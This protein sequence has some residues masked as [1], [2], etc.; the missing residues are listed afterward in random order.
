VQPYHRLKET[1]VRGALTAAELALT[2]RAPL[3]FVSSIGALPPY[4]ATAAASGV[5]TVDRG[6]GWK[7]LSHEELEAKSGYG[8]TKGVAEALLLEAAAATPGLDVRV[9]R[10]SAVSGHRT[11][12]YANARDATCLLQAAITTVGAAPA[13]SGLPLRWIPVDFVAAATIRLALAPAAL[14]AGRAFNLITA[15]PPL[16]VAVAAVRAVG[17][18][19]RD[20]P[21]SEWPSELAGLPPGHPALPLA[22]AF[23][24]MDV[25]Q[26]Q[27]GGANSATLEA[28]LPTAAARSALRSLGLP[29]PAPVSS[30]EAT[31]AVMWLARTGGLLPPLPLAQLGAA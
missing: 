22:S 1:N 16:S 24:R 9:V 28:A 23:A 18:P 14:A 19:V 17:Y 20:V 30:E 6:D 27:A 31:R 12:G 21:A 7:R 8:Q 10:P 3:T 29:W 11:T 15:S 2:A 25:G 4:S 5:A 26:D 13:A